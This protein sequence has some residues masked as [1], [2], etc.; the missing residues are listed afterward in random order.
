VGFQSPTLTLPE[1]EGS[2]CSIVCSVPGVHTIGGYAQTGTVTSWPVY[3]VVTVSAC[4]PP[5]TPTI[6]GPNVVCAG[7]TATYS[8]S[9]QAGVHLHLSGFQNLTGL[10][11]WSV[12]GVYILTATAFN[13]Y[14]TTT[15]TYS[16]T[17]L[18]C[19]SPNPCTAQ[20]CYVSYN[21]Y[22]IADTI[23]IVNYST[24]D[25]SLS[26]TGYTWQVGN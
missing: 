8:V 12:P 17:V 16:I 15:G 4:P 21:F 3:H 23:R 13:A 10:A 25:A 24:C 18:T 22:Q 7:A 6:T 1:G 26:A 2:I 19:T 20:R 14:G 11:S 9:T 5:L